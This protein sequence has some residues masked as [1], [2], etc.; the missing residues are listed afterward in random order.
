MRIY[1]PGLM[2]IPFV[3]SMLAAMAIMNAFGI[4]QVSQVWSLWP[5]SLIA[6]GV[7]E[8]YL[9]TSRTARSAAE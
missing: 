8:I 5:V 7:E 3:L 4:I 6:T 1:F 9:W 2:M